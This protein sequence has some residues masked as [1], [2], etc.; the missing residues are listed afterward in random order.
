MIKIRR[1]MMYFSMLVMGILTSFS[2]RNKV[3]KGTGFFSALTST[4]TGLN[5]INKLTPTE[6]FNVFDYMY[7]YNGGGVGV[8][9]FNNDGK[10]DIFFAANQS[11]NKLFLNQGGLLFKDVSE[12]AKIPY[13]SAWSTGVSVVD[14]NNDGLLDIYICRVDNRNFLRG[15]NE[16]LICKG[17]DKNGVPF[18][19]DQAAAYGL[20]FS[21]YST[22]AVFFD[23]D[24][25]GDLDMYL[26]NHAHL[27]NGNYGPRAENL[28]TYTPGSGDRLFRNDGAGKFTDVTKLSGIHSSAIGYGLGITAADI[29]L[30][31]YPD[32]YIGNDFHENDYLYINQRNGTFKDELNDH[33]MHTSQYTMGVDVAD[34]NNDGFPDVISMDM[35]SAD[36]YI[37]KRSEA[38]NTLDIFNM[39]I[40]LGYNYQYT[41]N[42]LQFNRGNGQFSEIG[43]YS[44]VA[45]TDWSWS[46]LWMDFDNDGV[47][48]LFISHGIPRRL[49][50]IDVINFAADADV[51]NEIQ[52]KEGGGSNSMKLVEKFPE[53]KLPNKFFS[54]SGEMRFDDRKEGIL[55]NPNSFSN[56]AAYGDFDNDGDLDIV[57]NNIDDAAL[58]YKNISNDSGT[59]SFT[60]IKLKGSPKNI[61]AIGSK[62]VLFVQDQIRTYEKYPVRGFMSSSEMPMHIG[63]DK[64]VVDSA[65]LIWPDNTCQRIVLDARKPWVNFAYTK[66]LPLFNYDKIKQFRKNPSRPM[67]NITAQTNLIHRHEENDFHEFDREPLIPHLVSTEGPA[68]LVG[69]FNLDGLDDVF[70]GSS[71]RKKPV[72]YF[73][74]KTGRFVQSSQPELERDSIYENV[75]ACLADVNRDGYPDLIVASGGNEYYGTDPYLT[76]RVYLNNGNGIFTKAFNVFDSVYANASTIVSCDFN[77]DGYPDLFI[78]GRSVPWEYGSVPK[79]YLLENNKQ[80]KFIDVTAKKAAGLG[81]IG[82]VT[83]AIWLDLDNDGDSDLVVSLEWGG[84][85]AF[86]N[87]QGHFTKKILS[88]K[89]GWWNFIIPVDI[90]HDGDIDLVA[91]NLGLNSRLKA[92]AEEPV[93]LYY[94]D[95]DDN[96][97]KEQ[98]LTYYLDGKE[99]PFATKEELQK[100]MPVLKKKFLYAQDFARASLKELVGSDK[101][102][103]STV[104]EADYFANAVLI[105]DGHLHFTTE[106]LPWK[107]QFSSFRDAVVVDANLDS[108]PDLIMV[109][110]YYDNNIQMGRNDADYGTVLLNKGNGK[111]SADLIN[112]II[113]K[114]Q[115]RHIRKIRIRQKDAYILVRNNDST[116]IIQYLPAKKSG[117]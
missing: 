108:L 19:E 70:I 15:R 62:I 25:D 103:S 53:I 52:P 74:D 42:N 58:L 33:L 83:N 27:Q 93:R 31:G 78:G 99:I 72:I 24:M 28:L 7:Y 86:I 59:R 10:L 39:K 75:D 1:G 109:G 77:K 82:F 43:L 105:N 30:D 5:F 21:G 36:P 65:F 69:D 98:L 95:F 23:Y 18:Y 80:G 61:N 44:G 17:I 89:K 3:N 84:I 46:P 76:P 90:D 45:A 112:G 102:K 67:E 11:R 16:L 96:G 115:S 114:G 47:K 116:E 64:T 38:E 51:L 106:A 91:G 100:Q 34:A 55:N 71:K 104:L 8:G 110:N 60:E 63:L 14:I 26:L 94:N 22:Q 37:L 81:N 54:N 50:D 9:D 48:D 97:K 113:L 20:D 32:L 107:A 111:F 2:C 40:G 57:V 87:D 12:E 13:D 4:E 88:D 35:L 79:S 66:G 117:N 6:T 101:I 73:Q 29:D 56:G 68:L 41:R 92:S 85:V 49:N